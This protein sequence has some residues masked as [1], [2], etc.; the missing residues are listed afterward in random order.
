MHRIDA[1]TPDPTRVYDMQDA[2]FIPFAG[3]R[4]VERPGPNFLIYRKNDR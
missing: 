1:Y 3:F 4:G 2:F